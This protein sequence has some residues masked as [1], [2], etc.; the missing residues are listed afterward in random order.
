MRKNYHLNKI[1][2][3]RRLGFYLLVTKKQ[4]GFFAGLMF[5]SFFILSAIPITFGEE[6]SK[7]NDESLYKRQITA[8]SL[9]WEYEAKTAI[10]TGNATMI[11]KEGNIT[12]DK[13]II[14]FD[15][16]DEVE[17]ITAEG[18]ADLIREKQK[19]GAEIIEIYPDKNLILLEKSAW[20]SSGKAMF[21]GEEISFDTQKEIINI[22]KG[23]KGEIST[24]NNEEIKNK[25]AK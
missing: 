17:K 14:F 9:R 24:G 12:A 16:K 3:L 15:E 21:K 11:S 2:T 19:C 13:M 5:V 20:I 6:V 25:N 7:I 4:A 18:N 23:V 1:I 22:T 8:D 10:F